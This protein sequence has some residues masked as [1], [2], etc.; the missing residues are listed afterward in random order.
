MKRRVK[1]ERKKPMED[2]I[3]IRFGIHSSPFGWYVIGLIGD[4]VCILRF[5]EQ[6]SE[7]AGVSMIKKEWPKALPVRDDKSTAAFA[8]KIFTSAKKECV[9]IVMKGTQFQI[10][11]WEALLAIPEGEVST[12]ADVA[13]AIGSPGAARAVGSACGKNSIG[14]LIPCHR[15]VTSSG[16]IGGYN[17]GVERKDAILAWEA[18][19]T[20]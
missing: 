18:A 9:Q 6:K 3:E 20:K 15:V 12:Y 8:K 5:L 16:G 7:K 11:V 4:R 19:R 10:R 2:L 13:R 17:G 1:A 14:Y